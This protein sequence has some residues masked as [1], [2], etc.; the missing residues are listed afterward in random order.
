MTLAM[1]VTR[2]LGSGFTLDGALN[3]PTGITMLFGAS[4][5]LIDL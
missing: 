1:A 2:R 5:K 4:E 3:A